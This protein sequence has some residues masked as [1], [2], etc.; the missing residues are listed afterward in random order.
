M[1]ASIS[2]ALGMATARDLAGDDFNV[3]AAIRDRARRAGQ[4][5]EAVN[6]AGRRDGPPIVLL[7]DNR[8]QV[9]PRSNHDLRDPRFAGSGDRFSQ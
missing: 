8:R 3:V 2:A 7:N 5:Y 6:K 1:K 9:L 4:G